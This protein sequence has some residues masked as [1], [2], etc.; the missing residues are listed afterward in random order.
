MRLNIGE[1][2][3]IFSRGLIIDQIFPVRDMI[4]PKR[5]ASSFSLIVSPAKSRRNV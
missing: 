2:V 4:C 1:R 5:K 3:I